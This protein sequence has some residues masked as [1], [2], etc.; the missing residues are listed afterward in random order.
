M[1]LGI[2]K[3]IAFITIYCNLA[4]YTLIFITTFNNS[5]YPAIRYIVLVRFLAPHIWLI[6]ELIRNFIF[7][8]IST[9]CHFYNT[10]IQTSVS[11]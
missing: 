11:L 8:K 3:A 4:F 10:L 7:Y 9:A 5:S 1:Q 6:S 2:K